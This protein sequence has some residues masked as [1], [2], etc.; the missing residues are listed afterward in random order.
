MKSVTCSILLSCEL[1]KNAS[2]PFWPDL[3]KEHYDK[4]T[5]ILFNIYCVASRHTIFGF[6]FFPGLDHKWSRDTKQ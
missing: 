6:L 5:K 2:Q 3:C 1:I 4:I